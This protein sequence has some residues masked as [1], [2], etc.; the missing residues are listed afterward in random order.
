MDAGVLVI[1]GVLNTAIESIQPGL[2]AVT[3]D[4]IATY[5]GRRAAEASFGAGRDV[6]VTVPAE[7]C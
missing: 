7:C 5:F 3:S 4:I 2:S 1:A 6:V